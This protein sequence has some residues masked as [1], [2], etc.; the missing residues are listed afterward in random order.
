MKTTSTYNICIVSAKQQFVGDKFFVFCQKYREFIFKIHENIAV[1]LLNCSNILQDILNFI[2]K[3]RDI[4]AKTDKNIAIFLPKLINI[5]QI[6]C[7]NKN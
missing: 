6:F 7:E 2:Q 1:N 4:F 3:Y 5:S